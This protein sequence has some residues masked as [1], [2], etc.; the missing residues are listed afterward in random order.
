MTILMFSIFNKEQIE[1]SACTKLNHVYYYFF[2]TI[3]AV[4]T[5]NKE[6]LSA[7]PWD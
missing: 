1:N 7:I 3:N 6:L 4:K 2:L 5:T